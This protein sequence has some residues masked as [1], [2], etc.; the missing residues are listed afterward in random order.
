MQQESQATLERGHEISSD[1]SLPDP[2][3]TGPSQSS[4]LYLVATAQP[5]L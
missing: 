1:R 5:P 4:E 2:P 3:V